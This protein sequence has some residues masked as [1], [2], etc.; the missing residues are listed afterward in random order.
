MRAVV[1]AAVLVVMTT[2]A[3]ATTLDFEGLGGDVD[4]GL[5]GPLVGANHTMGNMMGSPGSDYA[6]VS[7]EQPGLD[8]F[9]GGWVAVDITS[10]WVEGQKTPYDNLSFD[11]P[12]LHHGVQ[13]I[14]YVDHG[15]G[16]FEIHS[17]L[18]RVWV[19]ETSDQRLYL[20]DG[21]NQTVPLDADAVQKWTAVDVG[22][23]PPVNGGSLKIWLRNDNSDPG[24]GLLDNMEFEEAAVPEPSSWALLGLAVGVPLWIRRRKR[25]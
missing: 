8:G 5:G 4:T 18:S 24:F 25:S 14:D 7:W 15:D 13:H 2:A 12:F 6:E 22:W 3:H 1:V 10:L 9:N 21:S 11:E 20:T 23:G 16:W 19:Y 17:K